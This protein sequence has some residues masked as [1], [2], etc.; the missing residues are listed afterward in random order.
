MTVLHIRVFRGKPRRKPKAGD[1][2]TLKDST[3]KIRQQVLT[4]RGWL[5]S[6]G[7]PVWEWVVKG[8]EDD[9]K[10]REVPTGGQ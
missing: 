4:T 1:E 2:K 6:N 7:K 3:V 5:V 8:S 9:R 10:A